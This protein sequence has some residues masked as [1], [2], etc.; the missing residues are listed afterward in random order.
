VGREGVEGNL[1]LR[2]FSEA[3]FIADLAGARAVIAGG[4]YSLMGEAVYLH[5]PMLAVPVA[6]QFEQV[7]NARY[8]QHLGYGEMAERVDRDTVVR[9]LER[10]PEYEQKVSAYEQDGN[11]K[12]LGAVERLALEAATVG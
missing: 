9:F 4:G 10:C 1:T 8:L 12:L 6:R 2:P 5:K 3:G 7:L 11:E